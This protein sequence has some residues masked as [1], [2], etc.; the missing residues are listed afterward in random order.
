MI[1]VDRYPLRRVSSTTA[2]ETAKVLENSFRATTIA[3]MEEWSRFAERVGLD[4]F[5]VVEAIRDRPTHANIRTP[6]FGVGGYCLTK[7]PLFGE[8]AARELYDMELDFPFS[9]GAVE[10][11]R[12]APLATLEHVRS[13]LGG[14]LAGMRILLMGVS[15]KPGVG[16]TRHS[17]AEPFARA[18][19][20]EG[21][22]IVAHDPLVSRWEE[23]ALP[24]PEALPSPAGADAVVF[25]VA[26]PE[27][28]D[29]DVTAWLQDARP[30]IFDACGVLPAELR[31]G[32]A[33]LGCAVASV[34]RGR[35]A[36]P[37]S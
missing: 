7:D 20:D 18:A 36:S 24:I 16:D 32:L 4:L 6:G 14:S 8:L 12:A 11:N 17:P 28:R 22:E 34:G 37:T 31:T 19:S 35:E 21:A 1:D 26:H 29:L 2:S 23:L 33:Q 5:E 10:A 15:Y 3:L 25:A 9:I 13:L 27:Y 30:V